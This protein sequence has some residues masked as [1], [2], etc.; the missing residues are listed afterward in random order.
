MADDPAKTVR[1]KRSSRVA[2]DPRGRNVWVGRVEEPV[3]LELV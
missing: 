2:E 3:E 1:I